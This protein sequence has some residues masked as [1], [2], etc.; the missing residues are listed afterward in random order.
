[1]GIQPTSQVIPSTNKLVEESYDKIA[2][3]Y[4][5]WTLSTP[6]PRLSYLSL[7][8]KELP[9]PSSAKVLELGCGA[10]VPG[11][12]FLAKSCAHVT[13][14]DISSAQITL[15]NQHVKST[16]SNTEFIQSDM[17]AL[18]IEQG[19]FDAVVGLYSIL[20]LTRSDQVVAMELIRGLLKPGGVF[21]GNFSLEGTAKT[22]TWIG[23]EKMFWAGWE[24]EDWLGKL[25]EG[26]FE[27]L[28]AD[29]V[30]DVEDRREVRF[31]WI[32]AKIKS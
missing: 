24:K 28:K 31:L 2:S 11:T 21:V 20:H 5:D 7:L 15:A 4:L 9:S 26:G 3:Q 17:L 1:M 29:V 13:G 27:V 32:V 16:Y 18:D 14:V 23:G 10:G 30:V 19:S 8:L 12:Q 22:G 25:E 6:S